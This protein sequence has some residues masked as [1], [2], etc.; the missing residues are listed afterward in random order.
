MFGIPDSRHCL[1]LDEK[2][3]LQSVVRHLLEAAVGYSVLRQ[4]CSTDPIA[5]EI[6]FIGSEIDSHADFAFEPSYFTIGS[7]C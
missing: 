1:H 4:K 5:V 3:I 2:S 7:F 6:Q